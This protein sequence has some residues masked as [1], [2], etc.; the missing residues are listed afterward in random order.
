MP[1]RSNKRPLN[2]PLLLLVVFFTVAIVSPWVR[3]EQPSPTLITLAPHLTEL[4]Y[5][6][7]AG[8]HLVGVVE[9]SNWP[10]AALDLPRIGDAFRFD[11]EAIVSLDPDLALAWRGGTPKAVV[12]QLEALGI[13]VVWIETQTLDDIDTALR[14][15]GQLAGTS[16][17]AED[18][19]EAYAAKLAA[20]ENVSSGDASQRLVRIFY[21]ISDRPLY[22]FGGQHVINEVFAMCHANNI[23]GHVETQAL[24]VDRESVLARQPDVILSGHEPSV[25]QTTQPLRLWER[26]LDGPLADTTLQSIDPNVLVRPTPRILEGIETLCQLLNAHRNNQ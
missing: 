2:T 25:N 17:V 23:F 26:H 9:Y 20:L 7:G 4:V 14:Q 18:R 3:A 21:Q 10:E 6:S 22:T 15:I 1:I 19:A 11:M 24:S 5:T 12:D 13:S 16:A 8:Q